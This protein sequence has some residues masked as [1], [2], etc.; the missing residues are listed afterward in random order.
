MKKFLIALNETVF[1]R[2][3]QR[4]SRTLITVFLFLVT[5]CS[6]YIYLNPERFIKLPGQ[7]LFGTGNETST[8]SV[9]G[10]LQSEPAGSGGTASQRSASKSSSFGSGSSGDGSSGA[11]SESPSS[12]D[13]SVSA[14]VAFYADSQSDTDE[15]DA[16]HTA[17]VNMILSSGANPVFHAGDLMEDGTEASLNRF[18]NVAGGLVASRAFYGALGNNDRN[19]GDTTTPSPLYLANFSFP[20]NE[21]WYSVNSG[22]LHLV[23]LDSAFA[24]SNPSQLAWLASDLQSAASQGRITGVMFHHPTFVSSVESYLLNYG[25]DFV[26]S[27]HVHTYSKTL[28]GGIYRITLNGGGSMGYATLRVYTTYAQFREYDT[29]GA[30]VDSF[31]ITNR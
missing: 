17:V 24:S 25:A 21:R 16:R 19:G 10:Q 23:V 2:Q 3:G 13:E 5:F 14:F 8:F 11:S 29:A 15:E 12:A 28:S 31:T 9:N 30:L 26:I 20:N 4:I 7:D 6:L 22:N 18:N 1:G 27:G